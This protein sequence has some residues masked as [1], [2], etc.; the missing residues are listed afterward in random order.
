MYVC[1]RNFLPS[2]MSSEETVLI[3]THI[4]AQRKQILP[5]CACF[6]FK[7]CITRVLVIHRNY[8]INRIISITNYDR[9]VRTNCGCKSITICISTIILINKDP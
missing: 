9:T 5:V 3:Y 2:K 4:H 7:A 6:Y 8:G 1:L